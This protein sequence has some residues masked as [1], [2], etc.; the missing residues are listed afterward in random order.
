MSLLPNEVSMLKYAWLIVLAIPPWAAAELEAPKW[1][2]IIAIAPFFLFA[3]S[4]GDPNED[5]L[6]EASG[7]FRKWT[8][9]VIVAGGLVLGGILFVL[10]QVLF[11]D[12]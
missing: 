2:V 4:L 9:V 8:L 5:L 7:K 6:G 12:A 11:P 10:W 1:V 3:M